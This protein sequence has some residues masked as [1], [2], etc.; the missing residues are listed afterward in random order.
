MS[1]ILYSFKG[2]GR[3]DG[4]INQYHIWAM[5][6]HVHMGTLQSHASVAHACASSSSRPVLQT[7]SLRP[8]CPLLR[9]KYGHPSHPPPQPAV[10]VARSILRPLALQLGDGRGSVHGHLDGGQ[11]HALEG[12]TDALVDEAA[13]QGGEG[14]VRWVVA[15]VMAARLLS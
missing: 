7:A 15:G 1:F 3:P 11:L 8:S 2:Q 10:V 14:G 12:V 4:D 13:G 6:M 9:P 5:G